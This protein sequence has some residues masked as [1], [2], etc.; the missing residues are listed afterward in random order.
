MI[1][2]MEK[3]INTPRSHILF[4][5]QLLGEFHYLRL[6]YSPVRGRRTTSWSQADWMVVSRYQ[7]ALCQLLSRYLDCEEHLSPL[8]IGD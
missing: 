6:N 5:G 3:A 1:M 7:M 4:S 2:E 8:V